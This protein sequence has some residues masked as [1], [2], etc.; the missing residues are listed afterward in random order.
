[1]TLGNETWCLYGVD[2]PIEKRLTS[3]ADSNWSM[4][5]ADGSNNISRISREQKCEMQ[6]LFLVN[7]PCG[8]PSRHAVPNVMNPKVAAAVLTKG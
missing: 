7:F 8:E 6:A 4:N 3:I 5:R 2:E 1:M